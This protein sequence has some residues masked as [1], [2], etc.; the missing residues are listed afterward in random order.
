MVV[1]LCMSLFAASVWLGLK[2]GIKKLS[3]INMMIALGLIW[4]I[5]KMLRSTTMAVSRRDRQA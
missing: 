5:N 1:I 3:D 4:E 2:K